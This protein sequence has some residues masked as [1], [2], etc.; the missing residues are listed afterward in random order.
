MTFTTPDLC[1]DHSDNLQIAEPIFGDYGQHL[2]F[3]GLIS[4][5]KCFE[6][7]TLVREA[8]EQP[9]EGRVLVVDGGASMRCALL[10]DNLAD[11]GVKNGWAGV[12]VYG[13]IRDSMVIAET[14]IGVKAM[15]THP[16]K[17][18][19]KGIGDRDVPVSFA[20]VKFVPG[21]YVYADPDGV[22]VS[23]TAL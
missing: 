17:S 2:S 3:S 6:D 7:N 21:H 12:I 8:L 23:E 5:I 1:D 10:G 22:I 14:A 9:G 4:T 16:L 11:L 13:C 19:K 15:A 18:V 20:G